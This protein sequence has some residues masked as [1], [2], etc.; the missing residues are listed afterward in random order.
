MLANI[1][2]PVA[3]EMPETPLVPS[4]LSALSGHGLTLAAA[5]ALPAASLARDLDV[6]ELFACVGSIVLAA[7]Q[8]RYIA[9]AF[10][11]D[12]VPGAADVP[13]EA[14]EDLT[15]PEGFMSAVRLTCRLRRGGLL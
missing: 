7:T 4:S 9:I 3:F 5:L 14:S 1:L 12:R 11:K 6:V 10:D 15:L 8:L 13:G 2:L